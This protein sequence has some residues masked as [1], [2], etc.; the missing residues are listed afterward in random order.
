MSVTA[1]SA[2]CDE[3]AIDLSDISSPAQPHCDL[4]LVAH[5]FEHLLDSHGSIGYQPIHRRSTEERPLRSERHCSQDVDSASNAAVHV[6]LSVIPHGVDHCSEGTC[7]CL[8]TVELAAAVI[9][10]DNSGGSGLDARSGVVGPENSLD[11]NREPE[12][13]TKKPYV[14]E[15]Q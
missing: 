12:L 14:I 13:I 1:G 3:A 8:G 4:E 5:T 2:W 11:D 9:R 7:R 15:R 6:H 10:D